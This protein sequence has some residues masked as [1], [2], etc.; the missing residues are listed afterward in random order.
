MNEQNVIL[1]K[2]GSQL[3]LNLQ[4]TMVSSRC[5]VFLSNI[6]MFTTLQSVD[7]IIICK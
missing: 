5:H 6:I 4:E 7:P 1:N 3:V 2:E